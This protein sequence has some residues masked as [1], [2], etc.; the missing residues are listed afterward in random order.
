MQPNYQQ[1]QT[2]L[3]AFIPPARLISDPL[4][5]LA[6]GTDA[7]FYR[8][9][10]QLVVR[11]ETPAEVA[12][13]LRLARPARIAVTFRAAGTSLSGQAITDSVLIQLGDGWKGYKIEADASRISL[14]PGVIGGHANKY[15]APFNKKIGPDPAS[16]NAAMIGGIAANNASGMCCGTA[17]NSYRTLDSMQLIL[18]DGCALNTADPASRAAFASSHA[19]LL[20]QLRLLGEQT[21]ANKPLAERIRH[22]YRLK[23]T[24]GYALNSLVDFEDPFE[25]LQH[26]M[27]GSEGT[28]G[29]I[30]EI[31]YRTV[32]EDPYKASAMIFFA[33][34]ETTCRAVA[35]LKTTPVSAVELIDRAGLRSVENKPGMPDFIKEL[36]QHAAALLVETRGASKQEMYNKIAAIRGTLEEFTTLQPLRFTDD[37][38]EYNPFWAI[39]KGL[40]PAV[41]ALRKTGTTVIIE[42]VAFPVEQL[43]EAVHDL[44]L[45]FNDLGYDEALIF[46]HALEGNLHFVFTQAFDNQTEID[47]YEQLMDRVADLVVGKY[48]G[49]LKAEHGTG[50]NMAPYVEQEW[51][52][53]AYALMWQIKSLFDPEN[54]INPGVLLN[55]NKQVHLQNLK[56]LPPADPL[57]DKCIE[58][59][60][61]EPSCPSRDLTL[62][63]RQ[64]IVIRRE[65]ARLDAIAQPSST[66]S[67]RLELMRSDYAYQGLETCAGCGLCSMACPVD[68]NT[69]DLTRAMRSDTNAKHAG[70]ARW[71]ADHFE[72]VSSASRT[73]FK[74]ADITHAVIGTRA[75]TAVTG[76]ARK[77]SGGA[78]QQWSPSMPT[79]APKIKPLADRRA[80]DFKSDRKV[81]YLPSCSSRTMGL[82]RG[83]TEKQS[84]A[85]VTVALLNKAGFEVIYPEN[86]NDL[87]CG[88]PFQSKGMVDAAQSKARQTEAA[89]LKASNNGAYPIYS[90]TS[91]CTLL[92]QETADKRLQIFEPVQFIHGHLLEHLDITPVSEPIALHITCSS[93]RMGLADSLVRLAEACAT[94]VIIPDQITCCG[95][96][97]DKGFSTPELNASA[98]RTLK[99]SLPENCHEG[100]STSRT[101]EIGLSDHSGIE[102][103]SIVYL[104]ER[105]S[106]PR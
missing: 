31:T 97:G 65:I 2:Q 100:F 39:R 79:A 75:M 70:K 32:A 88:M 9:I 36:G 53:E 7:S 35:A 51:G 82:Q 48:D 72:G 4:R 86:L 87:C 102:Y 42:D 1:F 80:S 5:T 22:K 61:C 27:I 89:L 16:I 69:G 45:I 25:I 76:A 74:L 60:F 6:Y 66:E 71:L 77:I 14:Q 84:L 38:A 18:A 13:I 46:G 67:E 29:F 17:Q 10:P 33:D 34:I 58:C 21:Q 101:C 59:G 3:A 62:T 73:V 98:L 52:A 103:K 94:E 56:P 44:H 105:C 43:A 85:E 106:N 81:V 95:F 40:F 54:L 104:V 12:Q 50:R 57:I 68:I 55:D 93:A 83:S 63:P 20:E 96:A 11:V 78:V 19:P 91:P 26:L 15:L 47:R 23:N 24:T 49:S 37:P 92:M 41:G 28:L 8:L 90:D 99:G 64:R 30:S